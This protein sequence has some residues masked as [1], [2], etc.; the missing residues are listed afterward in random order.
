MQLRGGA[1]SRLGAR[2]RALRAL[3]ALGGAGA[4]V[5]AASGCGGESPTAEPP[6]VDAA[7]FERDVYPVL[8]ADC[9]YPACHGDA[10]RFYRVWGPGRARLDARTPLYDPPT[11]AELAASFDRA[12]S[13][14]SGAARPEDALLVRKPL[15]VNAGGAAHQGRDALGRDVYADRE[16]PGWRTIAAWAGVR[17]DGTRDGGTGRDGGTPGDGG[18]ADGGD[19]A[20]A[21]AAPDDGGGP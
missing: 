17:G 18:G 21:D 5:A 3:A 12:R 1:G 19:D 16:A 2:A 9:G 10:G 15:E 8:L 7:A 20:S 6:R 4:L 11:P 13:M 14:L